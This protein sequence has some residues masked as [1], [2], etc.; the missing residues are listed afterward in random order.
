ME[1]PLGRCWRGSVCSIAKK[2]PNRRRFPSQHGKTWAR[3]RRDKNCCVRLGLNV[4]WENARLWNAEGTTSMT[5]INYNSIFVAFEKEVQF[6][7]HHAAGDVSPC[8][9]RHN[10]ASLCA[11]ISSIS[12]E[13]LK[14]NTKKNSWNFVELIKREKSTFIFFNA[15]FIGNNFMCDKSRFQPIIE[16]ECWKF[17]IQIWRNVC[18]FQS[19]ICFPQNLHF[20][21]KVWRGFRR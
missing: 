15:A 1:N 18:W 7:Q 4:T 8:H 11:D 2:Q 12:C 21:K 20:S 16:T 13:L 6:H 5:N 19:R 3:S 9:L 10:R 17:F 14:L